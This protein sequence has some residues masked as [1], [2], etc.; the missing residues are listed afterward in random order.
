MDE[1]RGKEAPTEGAGT[2]D[3]CETLHGATG[4]R[5]SSIR[6]R[7]SCS[8]SLPT[9]GPLRRVARIWNKDVRD[10][11]VRLRKGCLDIGRRNLRVGRARSGSQRHQKEVQFR[12]PRRSG[13]EYLG[14][15]QTFRHS[16]LPSAIACHA[17]ASSTE[18]PNSIH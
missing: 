17:D 15:P 1:R 3:G 8:T 4:A 12:L 13:L 14:R 5:S 7:A 9:H 11:I 6:V 16:D 18:I 10:D 2:G